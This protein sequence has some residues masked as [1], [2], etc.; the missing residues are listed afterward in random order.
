[1]VSSPTVFLT[2]PLA[3]N[4]ESLRPEVTLR[5]E[6]ALGILLDVSERETIRVDGQ[7][8]GPHGVTA[9]KNLYMS[10]KS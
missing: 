10:T 7:G 5:S 8:T 9:L 2:Q 1:M 4:S 3:G 6:T